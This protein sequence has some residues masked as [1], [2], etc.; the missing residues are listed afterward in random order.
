M[1]VGNRDDRVQLLGAFLPRPPA[2]CSG[3]QSQLSGLEYAYSIRD[4]TESVS[5][6]Y[7]DG[8]GVDDF[9]SDK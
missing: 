7:R 9:E 6:L 4:G 8:D 2:F 1:V 5:V 3:S